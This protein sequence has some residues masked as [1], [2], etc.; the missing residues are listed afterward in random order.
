MFWRLL[1]AVVILPFTVIV[2]VPALIL[3]ATV[4]AWSDPHEPPFG[5][6][7]MWAGAL[8]VLLGLS[9][10]VWT[11]RLFVSRGEGTPGPWDPPKKLVVLGPYRHVRNP[12]ISGV[13]LILLGESVLLLSLPIL[14]WF[15]VFLAANL[16]YTPLSE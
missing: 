9:L 5:R 11:V 10:A 12:M 8:L 3:W 14:T 16:V 7:E 13:L 2:V 6:A 1:K 15:V 4:G